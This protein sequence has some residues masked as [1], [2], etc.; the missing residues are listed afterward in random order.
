MSSRRS[1]FSVRKAASAFLLAALFATASFAA[2]YKRVYNFTGASDGGDPATTL[3][4]DSLGNAYGTTA[5]GGDFGFGTVFMLSPDGQQTTLY[6]FTGGGDGLSPH[7]GVI[8]DAAGN[9]Y[10]TA[11]AGGQYDFGV[12][13]EI[14]P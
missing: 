8:L 5:A 4:F 11:E 9:L 1:A 10:G 2:T 3:S 12:V 7:G 6:S 13:W 14:T